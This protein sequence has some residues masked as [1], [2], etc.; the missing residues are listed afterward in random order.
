MSNYRML[1][2]FF[3]LPGALWAIG[4]FT[5]QRVDR[6]EVNTEAK[7]SVLSP[8]DIQ[9]RFTVTTTGEASIPCPVMTIIQR[10]ALTPTSGDCVFNDDDDELNIYDGLAWVAAGGTGGGLNQWATSINYVTGDVVWLSD[11]NKIY[12]AISTF[13]SGGS[14][15]RSNWVELSPSFSDLLN[16]MENPSFEDSITSA[17]CSGCTASAETTITFDGSQSYKAAF[18]AATGTI[19]STVSDARLSGVQVEVSCFVKTSA[20]GVVF[21]AQTNGSDVPGLEIEVPSDDTWRLIG[22]PFIGGST[23]SGFQIE[24]TGSITDDIY[25]D[26]CSVGTQRR[27]SDFASVSGSELLVRGAG[28]SGTTPGVGNA[29]DFTETYDPYDLWDGTLFTAPEKAIYTICGRVFYTDA[30]GRV[31]GLYLNGSNYKNVS[32]IQTS[33]YEALPFGCFNDEF[34]AGDVLS[35][36]EVSVSGTLSNNVDNH[37]LTIS[38]TKNIEAISLPLDNFTGLTGWMDWTPTFSASFGTLA[39]NL[40]KYRRVGNTYEIVIYFQAGTTTSGLGSITLPNGY[41]IKAADIPRNT[42]TTGSSAPLGQY[43]RENA[44]ASPA[45]GN[46]LAATDTAT[47][48]VYLG[49]Q[50]GDSQNHLVPSTNLTANIGS[51]EVVGV[52]FTVPIEELDQG[53]AIFELGGYAKA[54]ESGRW[55][56]VFAKFGDGSYGSACTSSPCVVHDLDGAAGLTA[57]ATRTT[58]GIYT[59]TVGGFKA[60]TP[61]YCTPMGA[62]SGA[63]GNTRELWIDNAR[64]TSSGG[65]ESFSARSFTNSVAGGTIV[66]TDTFFGVACEGL[67]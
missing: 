28:N 40:A 58:T 15:T 53:R 47:D 43:W 35:I 67:Y 10:D 61:V 51:G 19:T 18:T 62:D 26:Q 39:V 5:L 59:V 45:L 48:R 9:E 1:I 21:K 6:L 34:N 17:T 38:K 50:Y 30:D 54:S 4:S 14:F 13:T 49:A 56:K 57:S 20:A 65:E 11:D 3:I 32:N 33:G 7:I 24:A 63:I 12:R 23:S 8:M 36:R 41:N 16:R 66:S 22:I 64:Q 29:I 52:R 44:A 2:M 25:I 55:G 27:V 42:D 37:W 46:I 60:T 31:L